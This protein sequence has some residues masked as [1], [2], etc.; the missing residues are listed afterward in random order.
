VLDVVRG[1]IAAVLGHAGADA[2]DPDRPFKDLGFDSLTAVELRTRLAS[3]TGLRLPA[4][5]VFDYPTAGALAATLAD[6][7]SPDDPGTPAAVLADI[8]RLESALRAVPAADAGRAE[9]TARLT[10]LLAKWNEA[11]IPAEDD[12]ADR[13]EAATADEI[14]DFIDRE[15]GRT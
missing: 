3:A 6:R 2:V 11:E 12:V 1:H 7:L 13:I 8:D 14:F 15:L 9:V 5:M 10:A 4:T